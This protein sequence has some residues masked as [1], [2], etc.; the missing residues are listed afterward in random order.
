MATDRRA[1]SH[2]LC[3]RLTRVLPA[4]PTAG[5]QQ[6]AVTL[7]PM[8]LPGLPAALTADAD[9]AERRV[10]RRP[11]AGGVNTRA[12]RFFCRPLRYGCFCCA[13]DAPVMVAEVSR[14]RYTDTDALL[15]ARTGASDSS[16]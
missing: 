6:S 9:T 14:G 10:L 2:P 16:I 4:A 3:P 1:R 8:R 12:Q 11:V 15:P 13:G 5:W 7:A